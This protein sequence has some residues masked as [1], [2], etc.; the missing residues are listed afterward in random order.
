MNKILNLKQQIEKYIPYNE[1]EKS[2]KE[3]MLKSLETFDDILTRENK[4]CHFTASNWIVNKERTKVLMIYHNIYDSWAWVG[5]HADGDSDLLNVAIK[6]AKEETGIINIYPLSKDIYSLEIL[7]VDGH[8]KK[9][10]YV[11]SHLHLNI[12]YLLCASSNDELK[13][14]PDENSNVSWFNID[15]VV[16]KS[17][18]KWFKENIYSKLNEK[19]KEYIKGIK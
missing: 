12:T 4:I 16:D 8:I 6:E 11:N 18:E 1:Q 3:I 17:S 15:E 13:I 9:N 14:K 10:E 19:L 2:D 7:T 5:G